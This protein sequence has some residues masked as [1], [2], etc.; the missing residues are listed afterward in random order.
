LEA[1]QHTPLTYL[2]DFIILNE[3]GEP[4]TKLFLAEAG[5]NALAR[6]AGQLP[7]IKGHG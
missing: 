4:T 6:R 5:K 7:R 1:E 2:L 3:I